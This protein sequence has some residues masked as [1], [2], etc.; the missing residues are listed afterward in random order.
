MNNQNSHTIE[1]APFT[2]AEGVDEMTLL[3]AAD[4]LQEEFLSR[5]E[6]FIKR[7]LVRIAPGRWADVIYWESRASVEQA[8]QTAP[9][10][11]A[12]LRYFQL[13]ADTGEPDVA[14]TLMSV[15]RSYS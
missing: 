12:A 8:M 4:A 14:N 6:G 3:A 5:Q 11:S 13:M 1:F 15:A 7:D 10:N 2:L 9:E